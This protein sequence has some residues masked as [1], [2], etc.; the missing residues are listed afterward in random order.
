MIL[1]DEAPEDRNVIH[2][3]TRAAFADKSFSAKDEHFLVDALREAGALAVS[4]VAVGDGSVVGHVAFSLVE[5]ATPEGAVAD[6]WYALGPISVAPNRQGQGIGGRLARA[7][8]ERIKALGAKG[9][10]LAGDPNYYTRFGFRHDP[11]ITL[12][13]VPAGASLVLRIT[14]NDDHGL[15][16][17]HPAFSAPPPGKVEG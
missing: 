10:V 12:E 16:R 9:C 17:F 1:R 11:L 7:G 8:L 2:E 3:L 4:L 5:M 6:G 14:D 13:N 15:V